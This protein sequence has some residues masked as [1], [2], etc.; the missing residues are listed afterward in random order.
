VLTV[1][2][3]EYSQPLR[4]ESDPTYP[5]NE[6]IAQALLDAEELDRDADMDDEPG[7]EID[8]ID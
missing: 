4:V 8:E 6:A 2:G 3:K 5:Y 7:G 1:D